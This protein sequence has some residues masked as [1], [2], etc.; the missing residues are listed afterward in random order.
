MMLLENPRFSPATVTNPVETA[1][2]APTIL[3]ALGL[4]PQSLPAVRIEHTQSLP[5]VHL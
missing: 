1:Q 5:G 4:P 2:I 3:K